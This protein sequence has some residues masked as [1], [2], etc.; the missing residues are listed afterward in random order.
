MAREVAPTA[1]CFLEHGWANGGI[2][3]MAGGHREGAS[4]DWAGVCHWVGA[5]EQE[6]PQISMS[7]QKGYLSNCDKKEEGLP[8]PPGDSESDKFCYF[9]S[10]TTALTQ[11]ISP[12]SN[13]GEI[14]GLP[15]ILAIHISSVGEGEESQETRQTLGPAHTSPGLTQVGSYSPRMGPLLTLSL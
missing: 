9:A 3:H 6:E 5:V 2:G 10:S 12:L 13:R 15:H 1:W 8:R 14:P 7:E 11:P 4:V